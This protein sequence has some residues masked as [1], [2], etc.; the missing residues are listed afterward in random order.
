MPKAK[1]SKNMGG[2]DEQTVNNPV[3]IAGRD[4]TVHLM[5]CVEYM[6]VFHIRS[7]D[8]GV[9]WTAPVE[10]TY[11]FDLFRDTVNWQSLGLGPGHA[12][13]MPSGRLVVAFW[14]ANYTD[15]APLRSGVGV[16]YSDDGGAVWQR[17]DLVIPQ[18]G[19]ANIAVLPGGGGVL[20]TARN[21]HPAGR[22]LA[23]ISADGATG[24]SKPW[25][26]DDLWE[27]GCMAGLVAHPGTGAPDGRPFLVFSNPHTLLRDGR[28]RVD[29]TIKFSWDGGRSWPV[30][31]LLQPGPSAYS[32]V[33][34]LPDG[35]I[36]CF[37]ESG[38]L[39]PPKTYRRPWAY[40][41]LTLARF[42]PAWVLTDEEQRPDMR[43]RREVNYDQSTAADGWIR[44]G[45]Q[46]GWGRG[47]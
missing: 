42:N 16:V 19:E 15:A 23:A 41:Y 14:M 4:G 30:S 1:L 36:L 34:V 11:A 26:V 47:C 12:I 43:Q 18:A 5:Y 37:Y 25:L 29:V 3:A 8:D 13:E 44:S 10:V 9:S 17:G 39:N 2:P 31:R 33:A 46:L 21:N 7:D 28:D 40:S 22:R 6:R 38:G 45:A 32:D 35:T 27:S 24:W 20:V